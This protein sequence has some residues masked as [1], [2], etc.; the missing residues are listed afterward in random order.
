MTHA[1]ARRFLYTEGADMEWGLDTH[2]LQLGM[3]MIRGAGAPIG[4][5]GR[6]ARSLGPIQPYGNLYGK[7]VSIIVP[8]PYSCRLIAYVCAVG[9][10]MN[11]CVRKV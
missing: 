6:G 1:I 8:P 11:S 9:R 3:G 4:Q 2:S 5:S 10:G 7:I